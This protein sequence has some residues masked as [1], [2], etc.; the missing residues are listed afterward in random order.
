MEESCYYEPTTINI[1]VAVFLIVGTIISYIPQYVAIIKARS[2]EG[3][4][5]L[6]L[7]MALS[8]GFLTA[9][10]S[11]ILKWQSVVCCLGLNSAE[12][13][14][15]NLATEQL[16]SALLC[17]LVL[18]ALFVVYYDI[19]PT[20]SETRE[21][22]AKKKRISIITFFGVLVGS[23]IISAVCGT[24][25]YDVHLRGTI[26]AN[27]AQGLGIASSILI[28]LQWAPQI[29]TTYKLKDPGSLSI[30]MLLLQ[31]PGALLVMFFQSILNSA[32]V[33][34]WAPYAFLF[35][36]ELI[37]VVMC[38][39]YTIRKKRNPHTSEQRRLLDE[40][41]TVSISETP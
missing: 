12:C 33:T 24:L 26:L 22:R 14:K 37:L 36:E 27:V 17:S 32:D 13:I 10:N 31:M 16:L 34:T 30:V 18:Y 35:I 25:Y 4:N 20:L 39:Y 1:T 41:E 28:T 9:I 2:S 15:N 40:V 6:M 11:G 5:F 8:S 21:V 23:I 7:A 38:L 3:I 19:R 29:W